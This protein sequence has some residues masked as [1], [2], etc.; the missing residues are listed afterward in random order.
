[1]LALRGTADMAGALTDADPQQ[2][3]HHQF[4]E[5][6][7]KILALIQQGG[8]KVDVTGHSLGGAVAQ[9]T[10]AHYTKNIGRVTTFQSPGINKATV[11]MFSENMKKMKKGDRPDVNHHTVKNDLV[12]KA[13]QENLPG[14][15]YEHDMGEI[16]PLEA[17]TAWTSGTADRKSDRAAYGMTDEFFQNQLGKEIY[18]ESTIMKFKSNPHVFKRALAEAVRSLVGTAR[19]GAVGIFNL[20]KKGV[21][22]AWNFMKKIPGGLKKAS[23]AAQHLVMK[24]LRFGKSKKKQL[25]KMLSKVTRKMGGSFKSLIGNL[26]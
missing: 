11:K 17:H 18:D 15:V 10:A 21:S 1:M 9:I 7:G 24:F 6:A 19:D 13:G 16:N 25:F 20:G 14:V 4:K 22:K 3:G 2:V 23:S 26:R 8:G 12:S 5:N